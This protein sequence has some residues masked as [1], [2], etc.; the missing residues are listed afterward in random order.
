[1]IERPVYRALDIAPGQRYFDCETLRASL[2][3]TSCAARWAGAPPGSA[4]HKCVIGRLH[5]TDHNPTRR[6]GRRPVDNEVRACARCGRTDLRIIRATCLC[7]SCQNRQYEW[8]KG[9]NAKGKPPERFQPLRDFEVVL[10]HT[11]GRIE[12]RLVQA[13]HEAEAIGRAAHVLPEGTRFASERRLTSWNARTNEF[14]LVC[15]R[16]RAS[17]LILERERGGVLERHAWCCDGDP[18]GSGWRPATVRRPIS[19][20]S[21]DAIAAWLSDDPDL[22]DERPETWTATPHPCTCGAGQIEAQMLA[23]GGR[24]Q[25]RCTSCGARSGKV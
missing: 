17:G 20:V 21:V 18:V 9:R 23:P 3:T 8:L 15:Q 13:L 2:S 1:M 5:H 11:D 22:A 24:W 16:C 6:P 14:E 4:C 19:P 25:T 12:R 10:Q 7:V